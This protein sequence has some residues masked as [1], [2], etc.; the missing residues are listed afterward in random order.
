MIK[1]ERLIAHGEDFLGTVFTRHDNE[2][3]ASIKDVIHGHGHVRGIGDGP[4]RNEL[5]LRCRQF[6]SRGLRSQELSSLG[7]SGHEVHIGGCHL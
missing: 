6:S 3:V 1:I 7:L 4:L 2:I 5:N